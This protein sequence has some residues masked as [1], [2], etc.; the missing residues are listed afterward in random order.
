MN[1]LIL[2]GHPDERH[3]VSAP[4]SPAATFLA[5]TEAYV[6]AATGVLRGVYVP[7]VAVKN[8]NGPH[9]RCRSRVKNSFSSLG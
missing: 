6:L 2:D 8:E 9:N 1:V 4:L 3:L 5:T 7:Y